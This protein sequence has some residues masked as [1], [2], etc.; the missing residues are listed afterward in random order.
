MNRL[1]VSPSPHDEQ[2]TKTSDIMLNVCIALLPA[3]IAGCIFF[4]MRSLIV[5]AVCVGTAVLSEYICRKLMKRDNTIGDLSAVVTGIILAMNLPV[6]I[7]LWI[8]A[9][10][11]FIAIAVVKQLFGGLGQ[12]FANP[13]IT[14]RIVLMVSFPSAMTKWV[15]PF[16]YRN[17][18]DAVTGA[19]PLVLQGMSADKL[20]EINQEIPSYLDLFLGNV[21]GCLGETSALALLLGGLYLIAR[22]IINPAVPFVF[23]G[24]LALLSFI[25]GGDPFYEI[26]SGGVFLGAFFMATDYATTPI[27]TKGKIVFGLGCGIITF[28]IRHFGSFPEGVSFSILLMNILTP[29][30]EQC[31]RTKIFGAKEAVKDEK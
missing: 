30:I 20:A 1:T 23:I 5:T 18:V 8:A 12:N 24:S 15:L 10:G 27:S 6:T 29:Y 2:Y 11:S 4:G 16:E 26:L 25:A 19:T 13:A 3:L 21:G 7:P 31:T 28:V 9:L 17:S 14:A 22:K